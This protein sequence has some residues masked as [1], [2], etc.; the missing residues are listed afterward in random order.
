[1]IIYLTKNDKVELLKA[2]QTGVLNTSQI[3]TIN[4]VLTE[5]RP[6]I[7]IRELSDEQLDARIAEL[8]KKLKR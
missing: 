6:D 1:M 8:E 7:A 4:K 2:L 3:A 5:T